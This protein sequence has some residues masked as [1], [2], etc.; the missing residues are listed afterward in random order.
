MNREELIKF[1]DDI[2]EIYEAGKI[3]API[4]LSGDNEDDLIKIMARYQ[5]GDWIFS[6]WR[7]H[8]HWLL[9]NKDPEDLKQQILDGHSMS[10]FGERF[11]TSAIVG[12]ISPIALGVAWA[13]KLKGNPEKRMV[14][15]FIGDGAYHCG[16]TQEC[17]RYAV[18]HDLPIA[19]ILEDNGLTVRADTQECWGHGRKSKVLKYKYHRKYPHAGTGTYVMF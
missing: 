7:S 15:C 1:E 4:H 18:G 14:W 16:I 3:R 9:A 19:Y 17:I 10:V 8:Y 12:G 2:G 13:L 5:E 11:Y 6:T